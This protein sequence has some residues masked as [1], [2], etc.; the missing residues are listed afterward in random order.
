MASTNATAEKEGKGVKVLAVEDNPGD[1]RLIEDMLQ[2]ARFGFYHIQNSDRMSKTIDVL[3]NETFDLILLDLNIIDS[4][5]LTT[6]KTL[7]HR[8]PKVPIVVLTGGLDED[9]AMKA[10]EGRR[11]GL[12]FQER[13]VPQDPGQGGPLC[14]RTKK[15]GRGHQGERGTV[16]ITI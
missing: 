15:N 3:E 11:P 8:F 14:D 1:Y 12:S 10:I 7:H 5:G 2:E 13:T 4:K 6:F 16:Q 9:L